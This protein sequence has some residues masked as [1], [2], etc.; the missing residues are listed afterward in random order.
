MT[1]KTKPTDKE[2]QQLIKRVFSLMDLEKN[3]VSANMMGYA[4]AFNLERLRQILINVRMSEKGQLLKPALYKFNIAIEQDKKDAMDYVMQ[5]QEMHDEI[6]T[7]RK[8]RM[9]E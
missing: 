2:V 4:L 5:S 3:N 9:E 6:Q 1:L 7:I 8:R